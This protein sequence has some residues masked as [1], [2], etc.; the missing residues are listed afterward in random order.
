[1]KYIVGQLQKTWPEAVHVTFT[2]DKS[3]VIREA[4]RVLKPGGR[5]AVS[6]VVIRGAIPLELQRSMELWV[7]CIAGALSFAEYRAGL[8]AVGLVDIELTPTNSAADGLYSAIIR[9]T[10]P[11]DWSASAIRPVSLPVP[12]AG[13][14]V[15]ADSGCCGGAGCC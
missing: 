12:V 3:K 1:M 15:L 8:D 2:Q 7:G 11:V 10:K 5:F 9:A 4:F 6:D 13:L 14:P